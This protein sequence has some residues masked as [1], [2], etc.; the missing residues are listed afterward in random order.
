V[1][2]YEPTHHLLFSGDTIM[3]NGV[4]GGVLQ[5]GNISDYIHSLKRLS[6]LKIRHLMPGHGPVSSSGEDDVMMGMKRL[7]A[8]LHDSRE[9]FHV[10]QSSRHGFTHIM[11]SVRDLNK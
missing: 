1:C 3:A 9:L 5:S 4:V 2:F 11:R 6:S 7:E 8:L 10:I